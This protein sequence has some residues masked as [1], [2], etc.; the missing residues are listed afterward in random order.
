MTIKAQSINL[1]LN[2]DCGYHSNEL[3]N[4]KEV[5]LL[6]HGY[7]LDG[8]FMFD[9]FQKHLQADKLIIAPNGPFL[10]PYK[11]GDEFFPRYSWYFFDS[12]KKH[13]YIDFTPAASMLNNMLEKLAPNL[14]VTIIGYSQGGYLAPKVA[15]FN[16]NVTKVI[17]MACTF[18]NERFEEQNIDYNQIHSKADLVVDYKES[19]SEFNKL[20]KP[21]RYIELENEG[22]KLSPAYFEALKK[23]L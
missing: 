4:P 18:R 20:K 16:S 8:K 2:L 21:G 19:V 13:F 17:G 12:Q 22:H 14:P 23:I 9:T 3:K 15:E 11:K 6:L 10:I 5:I 1:P 7:M